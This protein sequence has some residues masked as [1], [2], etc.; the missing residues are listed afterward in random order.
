M[1]VAELI[2]A[3]AALP[4]EAPVLVIRDGEPEDI[5]V[6]RLVSVVG[7]G[8]GTFLLPYKGGIHDAAVQIG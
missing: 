8:W 7:D 5:Q 4:P 3:L 6:V 2:V 1:T